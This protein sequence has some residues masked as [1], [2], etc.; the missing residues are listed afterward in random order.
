MSAPEKEAPFTEPREWS[1]CACCRAGDWNRECC[2]KPAFMPCPECGQ[3]PRCGIGK[4]SAK[5]C[6]RPASVDPFG[7]G[8]VVLCGQ[9]FR[10]HDLGCERDE[11]EAAR[12]HVGHLCALARSVGNWALEHAMD[13][14][15]AECEMRV[16]S[17][18]AELRT[19]WES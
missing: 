8:S 9:H 19:I 2:G 10:A 15:W 16:A 17:I 14:A 6:E 13:L 12:E 5:R 3:P 7:G 4:Y 11:W 18:E 1:E